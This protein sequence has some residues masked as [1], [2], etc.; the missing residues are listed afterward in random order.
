M[1]EGLD[2]LLRPRSI[3]VIGGREAEKCVVECLRIGFPGRIYPVSRSRAIMAG[4]PSVGTVEDLPEPPDAVFIAIPAEQTIEAVGKLSAMGAGG[5]VLYA[6]GFAETGAL[7]EDRQRRLLAA[8]GDMGMLGPNC[9]GIVN[10]LEGVALWPDDHG[11]HRLD[12]G[13]ALI[14][15]SGNVAIS[16]SMQERG[17]PVAQLAALGNQ[18]K[19]GV[20]EIM[21]SLLR[22]S[23]ITAIGLFVESVGDISG[24]CRAAEIAAQQGVPVVVLKTGRSEAAARVALS[25]TSSMTGSSAAFDALCDRLAVVRAETLAQLLEYLK[26]FHLHPGLPGKRLVTMSC[27]GGEAGIMADIAHE[28]GLDMPPFAADRVA[29]L[30]A[31]LGDKVA[32]DNPLDYHTYIWGNGPAMQACFTEALRHDVDIGLLALD[33]PIREGLDLFGWPQAQA[34]IIAAAKE[35][36]CPT[37]VA[38][39]LSEN[40]PRALRDMFFAEGI[41][42]LQGFDDALR[43]VERAA[44]YGAAR[45]RVL[46]EPW[47]LASIPLAEGKAVT[48]DEWRAKKALGAFGLRAPEGALVTSETE[49][50]AA[51]EALGYPVVVKACHADL[52]HKTEAG[53]VALN[54]VDGQAVSDAVERMSHLSG[55]FIVEKMAQGGVCE[56]I[57]GVTRDPQIGPMLMLGAGGV[58]AELIG[59]ATLL[60]LP[61]TEAEIGAALDRLAVSKLL[62]G[63]RG[64]PAGDRKAAIAAILAIAHFAEAQGDRLIE[65]DVNPLIVLPEGQG[66]VAA[67]ALIR[68]VE[69]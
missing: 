16:L 35:S 14:S 69:V 4:I 44:W 19:D 39:S 31:V 58:L 36:G 11:G 55:R 23:R 25:H 50:V 63:F 28:I 51:A 3:A 1:T 66:A 54:L 26:L 7:G 48:L 10:Y 62:A 37:I 17:L 15:Q 41:V 24:F 5:V 20:A 33:T 46:S 45:A 67:D 56:L 12:R 47:R 18:A 9:Y 29:A 42:P 68:W 13:V 61:V 40:M 64:K 59:D 57:V 2:R 60:L 38:S 30:H 21:L 22:D 52:A 43:A 8:A 65:L 53:G 49:A 32:I 6:S 27:S 34:A